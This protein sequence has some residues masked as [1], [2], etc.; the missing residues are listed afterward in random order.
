LL[1]TGGDYE[2]PPPALQ[3]QHVPRF[4]NLAREFQGGSYIPI[5]LLHDAVAAGTPA[6]INESDVETWTLIYAGREWMPKDPEKYTCVYIRGKSMPPIFEAGDIVAI[7]HAEKG[8][9]RFDG[10]MV[11]F[12]VNGGVTIKWRRYLVE[13]GQVI[14][15]PENRLE[16]DHVVTLTGEE[17]D[18]GIVGMVRWWWAKR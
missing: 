3:V 18:N 8:P 13:K 10:K 14:G 17:I 7:D 2:V 1:L 11:A 4:K 9:T 6:E 16:L 15:V 12:R 5:R